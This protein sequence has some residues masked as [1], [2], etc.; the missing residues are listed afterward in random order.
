MKYLIFVTG[1]PYGSQNAISALLFVKSVF[2]MNHS[3]KKIFFYSSGV[4]NASSMLSPPESEWN[5]LLEWG[6]LK[7]KYDL[8]LCVCPSS[9]YRRGIVSDK[10][11]IQFGYFKGCFS[12]YFQ[13]MSLSELA[14]SINNYDRIIQF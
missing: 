9:S 10:I 12:S 3:V 8:Q 2:L 14:Y 11:A 6:K 4:Y 5:I 13:W 1:P 7:K